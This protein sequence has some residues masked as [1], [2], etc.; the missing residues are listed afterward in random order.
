MIKNFTDEEFLNSKSKDL[1][2]LTCIQCG[3]VFYLQK[4]HIM[5]VRKDDGSR[6]CIFC[7]QKCFGKS[8]EVK[9]E[10]F[11][12]QCGTSFTR[13]V[14]PSKTNRFFCNS[15]CAAT[16]NNTHK[17]HGY[18]RSK[19]EVFLEIELCKLYPDLE[20]H[21]NRKDAINGELDIY[22]PSLKLA[23]ELNGIFHY[24]PIYGAEQLLK[25]ENNDNRKFQACLERGIELCIIDVSK[26]G[27]WKP[28]RGFEVLDIIRPI[29]NGKLGIYPI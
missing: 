2:P 25:I 11:C 24:E 4:H 13:Y 14:K 28:Q 27:Y 12:A 22:I 1:L 10:R 23:I 16:Y 17:T 15:S 3:C 6:R 9:T 5:N 21:Y 26:I 19:L 20:I 8:I 29:L 7:S 18:R